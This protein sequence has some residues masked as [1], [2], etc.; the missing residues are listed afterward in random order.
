ME[1]FWTFFV[2]GE[3]INIPKEEGERKVKY[4]IRV[5]FVLDNKTKAD[6]DTLIRLSKIYA[7]KVMFGVRPSEEMLSKLEAILGLKPKPN[8]SDKVVEQEIAFEDAKVAL[9]E[10]MISRIEDVGLETLGETKVIPIGDEAFISVDGNMK[11]EMEFAVIEAVSISP[12]SDQG[13][14]AGLTMTVSAPEIE[15]GMQVKTCIDSTCAEPAPVL[16]TNPTIG[17]E[18][19]VKPVS[20]ADLLAH[21]DEA[22][23]VEKF[24]NPESRNSF[25][26]PEDSWKDEEQTDEKME[27]L[28]TSRFENDE[29]KMKLRSTRDKILI[30]EPSEE[31]EF[32]Q[33][34][35]KD[36]RYGILLMKVRESLKPKKPMPEDLKTPS[37]VCEEFL[38]VPNDEET[39]AEHRKKVLEKVDLNSE[40]DYTPSKLNEIIAAYDEEMFSF[41]MK[42]YQEHGG[43]KLILNWVDSDAPG[44]LD[45]S[46]EGKIF[47]LELSKPIFSNLGG[48]RKGKHVIFGIQCSTPVDCMLIFIE[49]FIATVLHELCKPEVSVSELASAAFG[50]SDGEVKFAPVAMTSE[51]RIETIQKKLREILNQ[52]AKEDKDTFVTIEGLGRAVLINARGSDG[53]LIRAT[54]GAPADGNPAIKEEERRQPYLKVTYVDDIP[55]DNLI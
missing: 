31:N 51:T 21:Q 46:G 17:I 18:V 40:I 42:K 25:L 4:D 24:G 44:N 1:T 34:W 16:V 8:E 22:A 26:M 14:T 37:G 50:H 9:E 39:I 36:N 53:V 35:S 33:F 27:E 28:L 48:N 6:H 7:N 52:R 45:V 55:I 15:E 30:F 43:I 20:V 2:D 47:T 32:N 38:S 5:K 49:S 13:Q 41:T 11:K 54:P 19:I 29:L 23:T 12:S 3:F 10:D